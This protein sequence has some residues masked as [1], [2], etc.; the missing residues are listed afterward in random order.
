M[1]K[2]LTTLRKDQNVSILAGGS[3]QAF[4]TRV[5]GTIIVFVLHIFAARWMGAKQYGIYSYVVSIIMIIVVVSQLGFHSAVVRFTAEYVTQSQWGKLRGL[6]S[7]SKAILLISSIF[8]VILG[9]LVL[10][11][12]EYHV[13][14]NLTLPLIIGLSIVPFQVL[15]QL[16][17]NILRALKRIL[18]SVFPEQILKPSIMILMLLFLYLFNS[19]KAPQLL[20][21]NLSATGVAL[22]FCWISL[23]RSIPQEVRYSKAH[24]DTRQWLV[25]SLPMM[26]ASVMQIFLNR[27]D[28]LMLG[29]M[30]SMQEVGIYTTALR[31]SQLNLFPISAVNQIIAPMVSELFSSAENTELQR[32]I[33]IAC[34]IIFIVTFPIS[35]FILFYSTWILGI[36]GPDFIKGS[37]ALKLLIFGQLINASAGPVGIILIMTG[38]QNQFLKV[39]IISFLINVLLNF[40]AIPRYG[41]EG[42]AVVTTIVMCIWN[43]WMVLIVKKK[44]SLDSYFSLNLKDIK[45]LMV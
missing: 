45:K 44:L 1:K 24:F 33:S 25:V 35:L 31:I 43:I 37:L 12:L 11:I 30:K 36:F 21:A 28:I 13:E 20:F 6:L 23:N 4:L 5:T 14:H 22:V 26:F 41:I 15:L 2:L 18:M 42:A 10:R 34:V 3:I 40:F 7:R 29:S 39:I 9:N 8:A 16:K 17:Q 32:I 19:L 38:F 27:T